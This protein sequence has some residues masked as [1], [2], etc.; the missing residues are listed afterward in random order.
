MADW[1]KVNSTGD[2]EDRR[3][4]PMAFGRVG[5]LGLVGIVIV[6]AIN[7]LGGNSASDS[8]GTALNQL[9]QTSTVTQQSV[10]PGEFDGIDSFELF[11]SKVLGSNNEM[12]TDIFKQ[13]NQT[14]IPP[15]LVLFRTA[16]QSGCGIADAR[17]GPFYCPNDKK[18]YLDETFFEE[19]KTRFGAR[20]GDVAQAYV[21]SHEVGHHVQDQLGTLAGLKPGTGAESDSVKTELQ[22]DCYAGMWAKSV[23]QAGVIQPSEVAQALDA[24]AAV[25]DDRIQQATQG[26]VNPETFTHGSAAQRTEWFNRG[27]DSGLIKTC[28]TFN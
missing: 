13:G 6:L 28:S 23:Q 20:G 21:I 16:T 7:L 18:I 11:S 25:G 12:W 3:G 4:Q 15:K 14:Y 22:A 26:S 27:Y 1:D 9:Q 5:G 8:I 19:L 17:V 2:V 10:N 24:A